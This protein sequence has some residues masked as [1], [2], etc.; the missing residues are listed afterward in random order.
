MNDLGFGI[1]D[2]RSVL[3][4]LFTLGL[5]KLVLGYNIPNDF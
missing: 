3:A 4:V 1:V 2:R 5:S